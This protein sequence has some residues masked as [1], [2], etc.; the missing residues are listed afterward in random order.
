MDGMTVE[1]LDTRSREYFCSA[2]KPAYDQ[3]ISGWHGW[4]AYYRTRVQCSQDG[5][6][7]G[8]IKEPPPIVRDTGVS[9]ILN[10]SLSDPYS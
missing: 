5:T 2:H 6:P 8:Y 9:S 3:K 1:I 4:T 10:D 7:I